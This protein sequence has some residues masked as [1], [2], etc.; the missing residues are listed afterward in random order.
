[1][2]AWEVF[3]TE[4]VSSIRTKEIEIIIKLIKVAAGE[5]VNNNITPFLVT[6]NLSF[7]YVMLQ[8]T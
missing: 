3:Y 4:K 6:L 2:Y 5:G 8:I 1:M 7:F